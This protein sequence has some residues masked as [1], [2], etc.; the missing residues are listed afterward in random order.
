MTP[1]GFDEL[2]KESVDFGNLQLLF[3]VCQESYDTDRFL[4]FGYSAK[5]TAILL[6]V[7]QYVE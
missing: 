6:Y 2:G 3:S 7:D 5:R 4:W 1:V